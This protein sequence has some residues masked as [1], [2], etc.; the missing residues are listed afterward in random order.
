MANKRALVVDDSKSAALALRRMLEQ[1]H[2]A[3]DIAESGEAAIGYLRSQRPDVI[4]MDHIMPG[5]NGLEAAKTITGD[6]KTAGIPVVMYTSKEDAAYIQQAKSHGACDILPKP[7]KAAVLGR[8]IQTLGAPAEAAPAPATPAPVPPPAAP[9]PAVVPADAAALPAL[10]ARAVE[11]QLAMVRR[12][13]LAQCAKI[14]REAATELTS[15]KVTEIERQVRHQIERMLNEVESR[16]AEPT[17]LSPAQLDEVR[18]LARSTA[19]EEAGEAAKHAAQ[20]VFHQFS[21][22]LGKQ[23][24]A[25]TSRQ[26]TAEL[27]RVNEVVDGLR[28]QVHDQVNEMRTVLA[29]AAT[30]SPNMVEEVRHVARSVAAQKAVESAHRTAQEVAMPT[31]QDVAQKVANATA[32]QIVH[33]FVGA[34]INRLYLMALGAAALGVLSAITAYLLK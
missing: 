21:L 33:E 34:H 24:A 3:V 30:L 4:F 14:A 11:E 28:R 12:E 13:L 2:Y 19:A 29:K 5:M 9:A 31:A 26:V 1:H 7:P 23:V 25:D 10:V 32:R 20:R 16:L 27:L 15:Q 6:P 22:E 18:H 8:I 17:T